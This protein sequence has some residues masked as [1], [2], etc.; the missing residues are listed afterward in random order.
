MPKINMQ[1]MP[2]P[3]REY[4]MAFGNLAGGLNI[5]EL[6][7]RLRANESPDMRNLVWKD[8][9]LNS[10]D[11]QVWV[12]D[13]IRS[14]GVTAYDSLFHGYVFF[15]AGTSVY[16]CAP[17]GSDDPVAVYTNAAMTERGT[18]FLYDTRLYYKAPGVYVQIE[19]SNDSFTA[20]GLR[21][22]DL[23]QL[24]SEQRSRYGVSAGELHQFR[25][26]AGVQRRGWGKGVPS[27]G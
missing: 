24:F 5:W 6:D 2:A 18:F 22:Y 4:S 8:G 12:Y 10:R 17:D 19:Y 26:D 3:N 13:T 7:Y 14:P 23:H 11:G 21:A 25:Q 15:H 1:Y 9:C 27:A 16:K 20:C